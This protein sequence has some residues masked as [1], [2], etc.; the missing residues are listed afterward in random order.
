MS[1]REHL[2][3]LDAAQFVGRD[4]E[5]MATLDHRDG[6]DAAGSTR[7][8]RIV[9]AADAAPVADDSRRIGRVG[10]AAVIDPRDIRSGD[11]IA[12]TLV[13]EPG[14]PAGVAVYRALFTVDAVQRDR[15]DRTTTIVGALNDRGL[16]GDYRSESVRIEHDAPRVEVRLI[17]RGGAVIGI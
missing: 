17:G 3:R 12:L 9:D 5:D 15:G 8:T 16:S 13:N 4:R 10:P 6:S 2:G 1:I 7:R 14:R 11:W